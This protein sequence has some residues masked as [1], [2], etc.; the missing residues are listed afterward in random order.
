MFCTSL[1]NFSYQIHSASNGKKAFK[2]TQ[3][4]NLKLDLLI[5]DWVMPD[6]N[7]KELSKKI[8]EIFPKVSVIFTSGY[9]NSHIVNAGELIKDIN[10]LQKPYSVH[11]L[12]NKVREVLDKE[13]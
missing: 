13:Q 5:T 8:Q 6:M 11:A 1:K 4:Q 10:F 3:G 2:L 12:L 7:G 9:S